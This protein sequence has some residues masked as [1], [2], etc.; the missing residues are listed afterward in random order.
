MLLRKSIT[1]DDY[2]SDNKDYKKSILSLQLEV[3][4]DKRELIEKSFFTFSY[5][6]KSDIKFPFFVYMDC[7]LRPHMNGA[8]KKSIIDDIK[9]GIKFSDQQVSLMTK[10]IKFLDSYYSYMDFD[11]I[12]DNLLIEFMKYENEKNKDKKEKLTFES[13]KNAYMALRSKGISTELLKE[14]EAQ[15][16]DG[17]INEWPDFEELERYNNHPEDEHDDSY[18]GFEYPDG[19]LN[20]IAECVDPL[21]D[22]VAASSAEPVLVFKSF[23][24][25]MW[26]SVLERC[27]IEFTKEKKA[28]NRSYISYMLSAYF[29]NKCLASCSDGSYKKAA[30]YSRETVNSFIENMWDYSFFSREIVDLFYEKKDRIEEKD[31][32]ELIGKSPDTVRYHFYPFMER[33]GLS[34]KKSKQ[35][36]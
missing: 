17:N 14:R 24:N 36:N 5:D 11:T 13:L 30:L 12:P 26:L 32:A 3:F 10:I 6:K 2:F 19:G 16:D 21:T 28:K 27:E 29:I 33:V 31:V 8:I 20:G 18:Y 15:T 9:C 23:E 4:A 34:L 25:E 35:T 22:D 7:V 1:W